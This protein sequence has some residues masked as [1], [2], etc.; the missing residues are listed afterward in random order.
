MKRVLTALLLLFVANSLTAQRK[1]TKKTLSFLSIETGVPLVVPNFHYFP[2]P[3]NIEYQR[4]KKRWGLGV[5]LSFQYDRN[6]YG[7]CSKRVPVGT[8][9]RFADNYIYLPYLPYCET[10]QYV[11]LKPSIFGSYYFLQKRKIQLF[12]KFGGVADVLIYNEKR[13][14]YYQLEGITN[15]NTSINVIDAGPISL[16]NHGYL[17]QKGLTHFGLLYGISGQYALNKRNAL[18]F[19]FQGE[20]YG[21]YLK[22]KGNRGSLVSILG[23]WTIKI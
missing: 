14:E 7:D 22:N 19:S 6:S 12:A 13:G 9:I 17:Q 23:G 8:P 11:G 1:S 15:L 18:R 3:L 20:W 5:A 10:A 4:Q 2:I 16:R 21:D